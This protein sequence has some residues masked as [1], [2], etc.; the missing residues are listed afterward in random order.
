MGVPFQ[1]RPIERSE[2]V[3]ADELAFTGTLNEVTVVQSLDG[4]PY[5]EPKIL[6]A[7]AERYRDAVTGVAPHAAVDLSCRPWARRHYI[8]RGAA[9]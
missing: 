4:V 2:L 5:G 1:R 7:L 3:I 9:E 8:V 6:G